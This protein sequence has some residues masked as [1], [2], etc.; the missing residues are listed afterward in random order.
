MLLVRKGLRRTKGK[1]LANSA[2]PSVPIAPTLPPCP[3]NFA[4]PLAFESF[5]SPERQ[6]SHNLPIPS[7]DKHTSLVTEAFGKHPQRARR[8]SSLIWTH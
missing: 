3:L 1:F 8:D 7:N 5:R 4:L 6:L 2:P